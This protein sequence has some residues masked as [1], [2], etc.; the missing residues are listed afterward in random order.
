[1]RIL[2][3]TDSLL[4]TQKDVYNA[5]VH[6]LCLGESGWTGTMK[7]AYDQWQNEYIKNTTKKLDLNGILEAVCFIVGVEPTDVTMDR[8]RAAAL[9]KARQMVS[10]FAWTFTEESLVKISQFL[11]YDEHATVMH[12]RDVIS[13]LISVQNSVKLQVNDIKG[14]LLDRGYRLT[15][16]DRVYSG[17][18]Q[19][20]I[21]P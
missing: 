4:F 6:A 16:T 1:M 12:G 20:K 3:G 19:Y 18:E 7:E 2:Y 9:V 14:L 5:F 11:S 8:S 21:I 17:D 10:Y 15:K 13:G